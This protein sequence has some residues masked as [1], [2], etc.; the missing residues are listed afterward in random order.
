MVRP[1]PA[2]E[3]LNLTHK[4]GDRMALNEVSLTIA[5]GEIFAFLGPNGGGKTT[6]F[7]I[8]STALVPTSGAVRVLGTDVVQ[9][10]RAI[11]W[12]MGVV[13]QSPSLDLKLTVAE[14][15]R[16]QGHLY[17]LRGKRLSQATAELTARFELSTWADE[18][19]EKLSGGLRRRV[20]IAKALLHHPRLLLLDEPTVGLDARARLDLWEF[21]R[22]LRADRGL[23]IA[24]TTHTLDEG[25]LCDHI[26]IL[27]RGRLVAL[28]TP[29]HLK[30]EVG[31]DVILAESSEP[32]RLK[33]QIQ[34]RFGIAPTIVDNTVC[35]LHERGHEFIARLAESFPGQIISI[36]I[37]KPT[38]EDV[39]IQ[40]TGHRFAEDSAERAR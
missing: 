9:N 24:L 13:F 8:L 19:A 30:S 39:F 11:R 3:T 16:H 2:I 7:R 21:L 18:S 1:S 33:G 15:L 25:E 32:D 40:R 6:L 29:Q 4:Y 36:T 17:G 20:E 34:D 37:R 23:T 22:T 12:Q 35:I 28:D 31:N 14:N 10:P 26:A 38:L 27:D 5:E